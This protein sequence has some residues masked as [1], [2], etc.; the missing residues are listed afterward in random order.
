M[1]SGSIESSALTSL[2]LY[3]RVTIGFCDAETPWESWRRNEAAE[4]HAEPVR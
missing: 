3:G 2:F 4:L 1:S